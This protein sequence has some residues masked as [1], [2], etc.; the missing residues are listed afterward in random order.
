VEFHGPGEVVQALMSSPAHRKYLLKGRFRDLGV[1]TIRGIP[2]DPTQTDGIAV[3]SEC[4][5]RGP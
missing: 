1:A 5:Y 4:G 2:F 3:V